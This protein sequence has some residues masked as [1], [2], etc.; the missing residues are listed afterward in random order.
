MASLGYIRVSSRN[1]NPDRQLHKMLELGIEERFIFIDWM[2]GARWDR[3]AY[4]ELKRV[5]RNGDLLY[6][7]SIDRLWRD[8]DGIIREWTELTREY[9]AD[10][11]CLDN[12]ELFNSQK[13]RV[14]GG[15]GELLET[16]F[17]S[18]LAYVA[19]TE[20]T[21]IRQ[22]QREG[23]SRAKAADTQ[24]GRPRIPITEKF[25]T[26]YRLWKMDEINATQAMQLCGMRRSTFY[27][28]VAEYERSIANGVLF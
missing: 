21:K 22:R 4:A 10:I 18:L 8:Y 27:A 24:M 3:P 28:R 11:V 1:Q 12:E 15:I 9:G 6:L 25:A 26:A 14:M 17:L 20:R 5:L 16:Q 13:F 23:I 2:S 7:N 19:Q